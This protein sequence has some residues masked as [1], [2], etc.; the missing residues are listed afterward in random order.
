MESYNL[1]LYHQRQQQKL[2]RRDFAKKCHVS[3]FLYFLMEKGYIKPGKRQIS[4]ISS[5]LGVDY[6]KYLSGDYSYPIDLPYSEPGIVTKIYSFL[7]KTGFRLIS[8]F[9]FLVSF[10]MMFVSNA[11]LNISSSEKRTYYSEAFLDFYDGI[12]EKGNDTY[13]LLSQTRKPEIFTE[14]GQKLVSIKGSYDEMTESE[15]SYEVTYHFDDCRIFFSM[16]VSSGKPDF[17][18]SYYEYETKKKGSFLVEDGIVNVLS[19]YLDQSPEYECTDEEMQALKEKLQPLADVL[20][21]DFR[22]VTEKWL[23]LDYPIESFSSD[24]SAGYNACSKHSF[25]WGL[26]YFGSVIFAGVFLFVFLYALIYGRKKQD[27]AFYYLDCKKVEN[28]LGKGRP[29]RTDFRLSP[30]IPETIIELIG[31]ALVFFGSLRILYYFFSFFQIIEIS[32]NN[33]SKIPA[34]F[35]NMFMIGMFLL[36]LIDFDIFADD[37]R[38]LRNIGLYMIIFFVLYLFESKIMTYL[39]DYGNILLDILVSKKTIPNNFFSISM[40]F[41]IMAFLFYTPKKLENSKHL[42]WY[43]LCSVLPVALIVSRTLIFNLANTTWNWN[44]SIPVLYFFSSERIQFTFLCIVYLFGFYFMKTYVE[45]KYGKEKA[46]VVLNGNRFLWCKNLF[47]ALAIALV[48]II[49]IIFAKN[50]MASN[51]GIGKY[52]GIL[53]LSPLVLFYHPH[54]GKRNIVIDY[55][56]LGLYFFSF[57]GAYILIGIFAMILLFAAL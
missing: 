2:S 5:Y 4:N 48:G 22:N 10:V 11:G 31:I 3:F 26:C 33:F 49:E 19:I 46:I 56:T 50:Q 34:G 20:K 29:A 15:L 9:L 54:K 25:M 30:F 13:S 16:M 28:S 24:F 8:F 43:R 12:R 17:S 44:L 1:F 57:A 7:S 45:K 38:V 14:D 51:L 18:G 37:K 21:D 52:P 55:I 32:G 27:E 41:A 47:T 36:Y 39:A 42:K 35:F 6:A 23:G 53:F 40:Y